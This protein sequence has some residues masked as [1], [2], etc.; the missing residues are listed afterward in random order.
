MTS[1]P[2]NRLSSEQSSLAA[3]SRAAIAGAYRTPEPVCV[4][5]LVAEARIDPPAAASVAA[6]ARRLVA[7][8]RAY[9]AHAFGVE[10]L[11]KE[12]SLSSPEGVALMCLAESLL[13]IPDAQTR[14]LLI[15]DKLSRG[16][17]GAHVGASPSWFVNASAWGL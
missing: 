3:A 4:P 9:R 14:D 6:L 12:F 5:P 2:D 16:D 1:A 17:W 13:R 15:R 10:V 7:Q 8:V 11:M